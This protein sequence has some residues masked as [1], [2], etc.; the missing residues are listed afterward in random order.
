M[1]SLAI[2][3]QAVQEA[4]AGPPEQIRRLAPRHTSATPPTM[5]AMED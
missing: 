5:L 1:L 4:R 3:P 2:L